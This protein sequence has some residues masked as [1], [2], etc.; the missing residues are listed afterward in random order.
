VGL[1]LADPARAVGGVTVMDG[2]TPTT[3]GTGVLSTN[4]ASAVAVEVPY[5][6]DA[7]DDA[8]VALLVRNQLLGGMPGA[9]KSYLLNLLTVH[10]ALSTDGP[11]PV[12]DDPKEGGRGD[13]DPGR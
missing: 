6:D 1:W 13:A 4:G 8:T 11:L 2:Q 7:T 9:G 5:L 12:G 10:A 3:P